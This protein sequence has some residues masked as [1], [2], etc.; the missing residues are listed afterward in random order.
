MIQ[1]LPY[2]RN[3]PEIIAK[4]V[5]AMTLRKQDKTYDE[6]G[7]A[8]GVSGSRARDIILEAERIAEYGEQWFDGLGTYLSG[9]LIK[10]G[11]KSIEDVLTVLRE[12][13]NDMI[14]P[15]LY[16]RKMGFD[17]KLERVGK[18]RFRELGIWLHDT[19]ASQ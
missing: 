17:R 11:Y 2:N 10:G 7:A 8:L 6:I 19:L 9:V 4:R 1:H 5:M 13:P 12:K 15:D 14:M 16:M 3:N 18:D